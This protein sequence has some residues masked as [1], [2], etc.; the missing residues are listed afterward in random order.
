MITDY[1][2]TK[3]LP[4]PGTLWARPKPADKGSASADEIYLAVGKTLSVWES[5][6]EAFAQILCAFIHTN[7]M[8]AA[9]RVYGSIISPGGRRDAL[10]AAAEPFFHWHNVKP[11][12]RAEYAALM[13]HF[14]PAIGRRNDVAHG[15][16]ISVGNRGHF[17]LP[18]PI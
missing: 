14:Q 6:E 18:R 4:A 12:H 13:K 8:N 10:N 2:T 1:P 5:V 15:V 7:P 3:D 16:V 17:L 9:A 11:E